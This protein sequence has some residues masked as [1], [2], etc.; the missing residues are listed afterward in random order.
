MNSSSEYMFLAMKQD[1]CKHKYNEVP[2]AFSGIFQLWLID[3]FLQLS[4]C[5]RT[6]QG[7]LV[8]TINLTPDHRRE[9]PSSPPA[10]PPRFISIWETKNRIVWI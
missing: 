3:A 9:R 4:T 7:V 1:F 5:R 8:E 2:A 6:H 10:L